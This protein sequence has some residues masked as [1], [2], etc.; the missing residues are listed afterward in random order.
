MSCICHF[1]K[2]L[3]R[4][5]GLLTAVAA[6]SFLLGAPAG[7]AAVRVTEPA[8]PAT[9]VGGESQYSH[10]PIPLNQYK[11]TP[12]DASLSQ[13]LSERNEQSGGFNLAVTLV[14]LGAIIHT[15]LAGRFERY[16]HKLAL[17]YKE[18]L[19]ETNFRVMHPEE[20]LPVSFASAIFHFLGEVEAVFGIWIIPFMFVCWKYYSFE[21]FSAYLNYDCSFTEPMFVMIIMIIA[22]SRPI[23][24][25]AE[26][27]VNCGA[28]LGKATPGAWW[29]SVMCLAPL[30]GSLITEPAA[31]TIGALILSKKFYDLKPKKTL[32]YATLGLLFVNISIGGTLTHFAAPPVVMVAEKW[33]WGF[34]HMIEH[35]GWKAVSAIVIS[36]LAYFFLFRK[37]FARLAT[38]QREFNEFDDAVPQSWEDRNDKIP[39]WVTL[40]HVCF[41]TWTVLFAHE[42][43]MFIGSFLF[44]IGFTVATPQYQNQMSLRVPMM[45]GFFLAGLVILGGVQAWWLEPVLMRL[46]DYAM[47][48]AT[49]LTAFNDNAAVTFLASTVPNLPEA[50][51]YSVVAGAVTGGGLTVIANAPNPA[52]QAILGK[53]F[54]GINPLWL[55]VW[56][57]FPTAVVFIFFTCFGH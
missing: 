25:L 44:F 55:F 51:K 40:A 37:E 15:F 48:G 35:F 24:K 7:E 16:S 31:M 22:S 4:R 36:N 13:V 39:V 41:L 28:K 53:Y 38:Q 33:D 27:V 21:D 43:V 47:I 6:T 14:F 52:G 45:V 29:I 9:E 19:K 5:T 17:R 42:P 11:P 23:F 34:A 8:Y 54:K 20:R 2:V 30:L 10:F 1:F 57:A 49:L 26:S 50:V 12:P 18:K 56:A 46:G 3:A 32:M